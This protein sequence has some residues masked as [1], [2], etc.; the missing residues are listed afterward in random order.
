MLEQLQAK[1]DQFAEFLA[2]GKLQEAQELLGSLPLGSKKDRME[3]QLLEA[4]GNFTAALKIYQKES[5]A[6][7]MKHQVMCLWGMGDIE[8]ATVLLVEYLNT[9][10]G[11]ADA[12]TLLSHFYTIQCMYQ[13]AL[14]AMEEA[15]MLKPGSH[16]HLLAYADLCSAMGND[17]IA[18]KY[19][20]A[21]LDICDCVHGWYG[22]LGCASDPKL[23][24]IAK[25]K[26]QANYKAKTTAGSAM[27]MTALTFIASFK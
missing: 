8:A 20:A 3:G 24:E 17:G 23:L 7:S 14:F 6:D 11:D 2:K 5:T 10:M 13:Q 26:L 18:T 4:K 1:S 16:I 25:I 12:W 9:W 21:A 19:Y 27:H 15:M 22:I